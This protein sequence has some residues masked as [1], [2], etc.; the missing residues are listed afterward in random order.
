MSSNKSLIYTYHSQSGKS[1]P[2]MSLISEF[3]AQVSVAALGLN[4]FLNY[5]ELGPQIRAIVH[6]KGEGHL[7]N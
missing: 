4:Y 5:L 3:E 1:I 7:M 6:S 2:E